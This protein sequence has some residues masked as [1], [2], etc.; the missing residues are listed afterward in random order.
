MPTQPWNTSWN[1]NLDEAP[2]NEWFIAWIPYGNGSTWIPCMKLP[3]S[4]GRGY[5]FTYMVLQV[6]PTRIDAW[7]PGPSYGEESNLTRNTVKT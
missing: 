6:A 4:S 1:T 2:L 5:Y 7:L 3:Y